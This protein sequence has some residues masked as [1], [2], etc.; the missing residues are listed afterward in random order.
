MASV[1]PRLCRIRPRTVP[2]AFVLPRTLPLLPATAPVEWGTRP[3]PFA[4][5]FCSNT[6][7]VLSQAAPLSLNKQKLT[8]EVAHALET[9]ELQTKLELK[10]RALVKAI[11]SSKTYRFQLSSE[12][13][14]SEERLDLALQEFVDMT[15]EN[16]SN[17]YRGPAGRLE[18]L[19]TLLLPDT[20]AAVEVDDAF[21]APQVQR[22]HEDLALAAPTR[23]A[24]P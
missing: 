10:L 3:R 2:S 18:F 20:D 22:L 19:S 21:L 12:M 7:S 5:S 23:P 6:T 11:A 15:L 8:L 4:R 17:T 24:A 13:N 9:G 16:V 1:L 14:L